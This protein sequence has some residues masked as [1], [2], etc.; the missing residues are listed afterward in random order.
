[1]K[2]TVL[3]SLH[4]TGYSVVLKFVETSQVEELTNA[5]T[6]LFLW[7]L[8]LLGPP[9]VKVQVKFNGFPNITEGDSGVSITFCAVM[10]E[11]I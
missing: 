1:M 8:K 6:K 4:D 9:V 3:L 11:T 2:F 5:R 10:P 7:I